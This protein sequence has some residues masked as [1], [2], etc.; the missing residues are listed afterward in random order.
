MARN[1]FASGAGLWRGPVSILLAI[2]Q[3][4]VGVPAGAVSSSS[5]SAGVSA[6]GG[7]SLVLDGAVTRVKVALAAMRPR[8]GTANGVGSALHS[9][10]EFSQ[11]TAQF[12]E[13]LVATASTSP[14]EDLALYQ[15]LR[16]HKAR[17]NEDDLPRS[18]RRFCPI[19]RAR[20][21][22]LRCSPTSG[23]L[24][25]TTVISRKPFLPGSNLGKLAAL[26]Q[27]HRPRL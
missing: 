9:P 10:G 16:S 6:S 15:A 17:A 11:L 18:R 1:P 2:A 20:A 22:A 4:G 7:S 26:S 13:P 8:T 27:T 12:E 19:I 25:T 23:C 3:V 5:M 21:R 14:A 24:T